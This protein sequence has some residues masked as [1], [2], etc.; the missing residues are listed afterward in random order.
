MCLRL[1][2]AAEQSED[3]KNRAGMESLGVS[4]FLFAF[5]RRLYMS[6]EFSSLCRV[7]VNFSLIY[8]HIV[9]VLASMLPQCFLVGLHRA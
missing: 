9:H 8:E 6:S 3:P 5:T 1:K 7:L 4:I 2:A